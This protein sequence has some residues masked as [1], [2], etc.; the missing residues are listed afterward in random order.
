MS[1]T[2][3]LSIGT[4]IQLINTSI[5]LRWELWEIFQLTTNQSYFY[6]DWTKSPRIFVL[7]VKVVQT[8]KERTEENFE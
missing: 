2:L 6:E 5:K 3:R 1:D 7:E 8:E 4:I